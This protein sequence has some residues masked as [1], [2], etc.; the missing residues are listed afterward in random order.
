M[1]LVVV[2]SSALVRRRVA[3]RFGVNTSVGIVNSIGHLLVGTI[4]FDYRRGTFYE[5]VSIGLWNWR[6]RGIWRDLLP[7]DLRGWPLWPFLKGI[8][9]A[10]LTM[11]FR[12][13][14][15]S[16]NRDLRWLEGW[17]AKRAHHTTHEVLR[18]PGISS[19]ISR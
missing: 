6:N 18:H 4:F 16:F 15:V 11:R 1:R 8:A 19:A 14:E 9:A 2:L 5:G 12:F 10:G 7:S 17:L 13:A 3:G